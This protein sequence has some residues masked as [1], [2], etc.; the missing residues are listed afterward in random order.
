MKVAHDGYDFHMW[1]NDNYAAS[2]KVLPYL[3]QDNAGNVVNSTCGFFQFNSDVVYQN[4][5]ATQD[6]TAVQE[7]INSI[8]NVRFLADSDWAA[9]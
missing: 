6:A 2:M 4:Y 1:I 7:A 3:F 8:E 9:D 5:S